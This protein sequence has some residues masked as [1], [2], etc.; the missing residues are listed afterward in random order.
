MGAMNRCSAGRSTVRMRSSAAS[1]TL[2]CVFREELAHLVRWRARHR[3]LL[4]RVSVLFGLTAIIDVIGAVLT[5]HFER[6]REDGD[7]HTFWDAFFFSTVQLLTVSSQ[8]RN[9]FTVGGRIV[10]IVLEAWAIVVV[11]AI[12]GSF[13]AF[14]LRSED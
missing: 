1:E 4:A 8:I 2:R 12:A 13:A 10:D 9:P 3:R 11:A 14:F 6:G 5:W 7:I